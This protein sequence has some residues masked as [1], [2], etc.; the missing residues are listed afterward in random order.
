MKTLLD[1]FEAELQDIYDA[2]HRISKAL[3]KMAEAATCM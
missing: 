1:L 2:E 3:P